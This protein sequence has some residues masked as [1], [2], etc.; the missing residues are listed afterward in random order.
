MEDGLENKLGDIHL[1]I[2]A[3]ITKAESYSDNLRIS[4]NESVT[5][6]GY[7]LKQDQKEDLTNLTSAANYLLDN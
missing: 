5:K 7:Y 6:L 1:K 4:L 3:F 2:T